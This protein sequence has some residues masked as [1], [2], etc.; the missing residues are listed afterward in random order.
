MRH[1][2]FIVSGI[3]FLRGK[4]KIDLERA[5][6]RRSLDIERQSVLDPQH[7]IYFNR[8]PTVVSSRKSISFG[9][10]HVELD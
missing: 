2:I 6:V 1:D 5:R 8:P 7:W 10:L 9:E 3:H 4:Y